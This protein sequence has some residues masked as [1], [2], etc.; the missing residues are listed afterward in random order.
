M[1]FLTPLHHRALIELTGIDKA[2]FLQGLVTNDVRWV[3]QG[4]PI[5]TALL[6]PQG[7]FLFD[8][9]IFQKENSWLIDCERERTKELINRLS[10]YK[11][12]SKIEIT[13]LSEHYNVF[14]AST[15]LLKSNE[16]YIEDPRLKELGYRLYTKNKM[17]VEF[18]NNYENHRISL[19][20]PDGSRDIPINKG[21]ILEYGFHELHAIDWEKGC[22]M[23]QELT[24]RTRYRGL[25][26][27]RLLPVEIQG[28]SP[29]PFSPIFLGTEEVGEIRTT[30][31]GLGLALLRLTP[32]KDFGSKLHCGKSQLTPYIP[33][34]VQLP[35]IED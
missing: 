33:D 34:W 17:N 27:K 20:I 5:Y 31:P 13:D 4:K 6:T 24:A 35:V 12:R 8:L 26:R 23:G 3:E 9:F 14:A 21:I 7:K 32:T 29:P 28:E 1:T 11:L 18:T 2:S 16:I 30:V 19:G 22:Y 25:V 10:I 15:D